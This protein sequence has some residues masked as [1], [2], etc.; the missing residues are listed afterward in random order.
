MAEIRQY[1]VSGK[2]APM[3][4]KDSI[5]DDENRTNF[6]GESPTSK[7]GAMINSPEQKYSECPSVS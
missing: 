1:Q 5:A 4:A 7:A 3:V 6:Q 2:S